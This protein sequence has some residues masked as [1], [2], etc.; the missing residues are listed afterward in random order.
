[1]HR[2]SGS[3]APRSRQ[4]LPSPDRSGAQS[5]QATR[6]FILND[7]GR[8]MNN[9]DLQI[10][11]RPT[12]LRTQVEERIRSAISHGEFEPG[13]RLV[14]RELCELIGVGRTS[15]RE[16]LRQL[17]AEGLVTVFPHRGPM[18]S[19]LSPEEARHLYSVRA[20]LEGYAGRMFATRR[21]TRDLD[22]LD[23]TYSELEAAARTQ[24]QRA[25]V[26]AKSAFYAVLLEGSGNPFLRQMLTVIHNRVNLLRAT[27]MLQPNR[28]EKSL[29]EIRRICVAIHAGDEVEAEAAC[30]A[31]IEAAA[32]TLHN[33]LQEHGSDEGAGD[34]SGVRTWSN[35]APSPA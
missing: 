31:H 5:T 11:P 18:V 2:L 9:Q 16:A 26:G 15:I 25:L 29:E 7:S 1:M 32:A 8:S 4:R 20:L 6:R 24:D 33:V 28:V 13:Q 3:I 23:S 19:E 30:I 34:G 14:E 27:S 17:E 12:T 35:R 22:R 21:T 10:P